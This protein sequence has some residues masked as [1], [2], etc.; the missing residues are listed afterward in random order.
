M[1]APMAR[2]RASQEKRSAS[3]MPATSAAIHSTPEPAKPS[4]R[5]DSGPACPARRRHGRAAAAPSGTGAS[6]PAPQLAAI[7]STR[8]S[9]KASAGQQR[10]K[11][12]LAVLRGCNA[13]RQADSQARRPTGTSH[14]TEKPNRK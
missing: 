8:P 2:P 11:R 3:A 13:Q 5:I 7:S 4:Q 12:A 10:R 9:Q 1:R 6:I 14:Q